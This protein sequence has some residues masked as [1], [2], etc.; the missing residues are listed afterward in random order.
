MGEAGVR[1]LVDTELAGKGPLLIADGFAKQ[2]TLPVT[3]SAGAH[4]EAPVFAGELPATACAVWQRSPQTMP[5]ASW[6]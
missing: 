2:L 4:L 1:T 3:P 5:A 6:S